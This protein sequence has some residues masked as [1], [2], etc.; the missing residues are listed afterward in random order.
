MM[1]KARIEGRLEF[2][3]LWLIT[4][5]EHFRAFWCYLLLKLGPARFHEDEVQVSFLVRQT[6]FD[7]GIIDMNYAP[8]IL[9]TGKLVF[10]DH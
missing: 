3:I 1:G 4:L 7:G 2:L 6:P 9:S 8:S 5:N 10:W